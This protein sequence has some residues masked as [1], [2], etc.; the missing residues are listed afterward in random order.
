M[1]GHK[2]AFNWANISFQEK[3]LT[4][5]KG[6]PVDIGCREFHINSSGPFFSSL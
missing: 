3:G 5:N 1:R 2:L 4:L 6:I